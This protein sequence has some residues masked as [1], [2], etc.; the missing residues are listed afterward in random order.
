[1]N[2]VQ[3][4]NR[5]SQAMRKRI[6]DAALKLFRAGGVRNVTMRSIAGR[7]GYSPA[8]IYG[9]FEGKEDI[10]RRLS[11]SGFEQLL[12]RMRPLAES[13]ADPVERLV[14]GARIYLEFAAQNPDIYQLMFASEDVHLPLDGPTNDAAHQT[15]QL[16]VEVIVECIER[17][18]IQNVEDPYVPALSVWSMVHGLAM[19]RIKDRLKRLPH[20]DLDAVAWDAVRFALR[21]IVDGEALAPGVASS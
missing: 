19:L 17:G 15:F 6:L 7:I 2:S 12:E 4:K 14:G 3:R 16:L 1:M 21:P 10:L 5:Q 18:S 11:I 8:A 20:E 13:G 9:Y